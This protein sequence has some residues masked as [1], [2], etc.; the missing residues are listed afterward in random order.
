MAEP[1]CVHIDPEPLADAPRRCRCGRWGYITTN[2]LL[3]NKI[4]TGMF[5][6]GVYDNLPIRMTDGKG[7]PL[8]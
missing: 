5:I 4:P 6:T 7:E 1:P 8:G 2:A 3:K